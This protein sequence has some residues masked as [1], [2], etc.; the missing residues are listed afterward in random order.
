MISKRAPYVFSHAS[1]GMTIFMKNRAL[2]FYENDCN[3]S[4]CILKAAQACL[5]TAIP[6]ESIKMCAGLGDGFGVS[7]M[8]G[9]LIAGVMVLSAAYEGTELKRARLR[10]LDGFKSEFSHYDCGQ[11][12]TKFDCEDII[13]TV[14]DLLEKLL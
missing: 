1:K 4:Q 5:N 9:A 13:A 2:E 6:N 3:C 8:C 10:L 11:L 14:C 7:K 12:K